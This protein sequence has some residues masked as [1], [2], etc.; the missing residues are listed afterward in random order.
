[1]P[2]RVANKNKNKNIVYGDLNM[3]DS[4]KPLNRDDLYIVVPPSS[5]HA[6][7]MNFNCVCV[8]G[9]YPEWLDDDEEVIPVDA[10]LTV[11]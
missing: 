2:I 10:T 11:E 1:M 5:T 6:E 3:G 8:Q 7:A 9:G 4:F